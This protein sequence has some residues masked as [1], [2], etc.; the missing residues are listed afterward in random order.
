[1]RVHKIFIASLIVFLASIA[2][3][4]VFSSQSFALNVY[5]ED[6][7]TGRGIYGYY[8]NGTYG[9]GASFSGS[10][11]IELLSPSGSY[12]KYLY[13]INFNF[14][15]YVRN[16]AYSYEINAT[17]RIN[18]NGSNLTP[19]D[20]IFNTTLP[21][22]AQWVYAD[23]SIENTTDDCSVAVYDFYNLDISCIGRST[24]VPRTLR[25]TYGYTNSF[26]HGTQD[27]IGLW[28]SFAYTGAIRISAANIVY[29][30]FDSASDEEALDL[31]QISDS[32]ENIH[33][34]EKD[35]INDSVN[36]ASDSASSIDTSGFRLSDP[37]A[38]W[39]SAFSNQGRV[40]IPKLASWILSNES[41]VCTPWP[42]DVRNN[43]TP[44]ANV[45]AIMVAFGLIIR[46]LKANSVENS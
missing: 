15:I 17:F 33:Q 23:Q 1:M 22:T 16:Q 30:E 13:G 19:S 12:T 38:P 14:P 4:L 21:I 24:K 45:L 6:L 36:D 2:C 29:T 5:S 44:V 42:S 20:S 35:T 9:R 34:D 8:I 46:W 7:T 26:T 32:L 40:N 28:N 18:Q 27:Y 25:L 43:L 3:T 37:F 31:G 39:W 10:F 11:P 41:R